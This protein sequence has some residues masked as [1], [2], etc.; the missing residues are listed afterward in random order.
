MKAVIASPDVYFPQIM[1]HYPPGGGGRTFA[2]AAAYAEHMAKPRMWADEL[3]MTFVLSICSWAGSRAAL[4]AK[5]NGG[6]ELPG[7]QS[8]SQKVPYLLYY[9]VSKKIQ[10]SLSPA[11]HTK[12]RAVPPFI[13]LT[14]RDQTTQPPFE[15]AGSR[16]S[17]ISGCLLVLSLSTHKPSLKM[18]RHSFLLHLVLALFAAPFAAAASA[19]NDACLIDCAMGAPSCAAA[20]AAPV[21]SR[22]TVRFS[23]ISGPSFDV[24]VESARAP[25]MASR[26]YVLSSLQYFLGA[27]FYRVLR[28]ASASFVAQVGYRGVPAVD[29]AWIAE[30][31]SNATVA[32][33]PPG[34]VRGSVAFGTSEVPGPR[35]NCTAAACSLGFSVELFINTADNARL[36]AA[37][38]SPFGTIDDAG[39]RVVDAL[40]AS[41][42]ELADLCAGGDSDEWCVPDGAGWAGVNL[43]RFLAEGNAYARAAFP[44]LDA[45]AGVSIVARE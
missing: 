44:R 18:R 23:L 45:V 5:S 7:G 13:D 3:E 33:A 16:K 2:T 25:P 14:H 22:F 43:T 9:L 38:F 42:G 40:Y 29:A 15:P 4:P 31:T 11:S 34:N 6:E 36:D 37:D 17:W 19:C 28:D 35:G 20:W 12:I 8:Y 21:P 27:P 26:F 24:R 41:Y 39:M 30:R 10:N 1:A 32:V